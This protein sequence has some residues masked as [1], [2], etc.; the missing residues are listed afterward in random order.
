MASTRR[1][2]TPLRGSSLIRRSARIL[3]NPQPAR[4]WVNVRYPGHDPSLDRAIERL[5]GRRSHDSGY[6]FLRS[7]RDLGFEMPTRRGALAAAKRIHD[8]KLDVQVFLSK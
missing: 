3:K 6:D 5:V 2:R 8:S 7:V 4:W 1:P